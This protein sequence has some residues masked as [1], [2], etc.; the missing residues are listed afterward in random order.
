MSKVKIKFLG[1]HKVKRYYKA[2]NVSCDTNHPETCTIE[3]EAKQA[4]QIT[5]DFPNE[6]EF[7]KKDGAE[8]IAKEITEYQNKMIS[9]V[10]STRGI[11]I[12]E[13]KSVLTKKKI[14][15]KPVE[16]KPPEKPVKPTKKVRTLK[17]SRRKK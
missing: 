7:I 17:R 3:I 1:V 16:I 14:E 10:D 2:G 12:I 4:A 8:M 6:W 9:H 15:P 11:K 5:S 13:N